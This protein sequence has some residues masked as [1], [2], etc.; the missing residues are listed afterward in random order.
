MDNTNTVPKY[1]MT[2]SQAYTEQVLSAQVQ[3]S[4][5]IDDASEDQLRQLEPLMKVFA[6]TISSEFYGSIEVKLE[7]GK[8]TIIKKTESI[9]I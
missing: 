3:S 5:I 8:V 2:N 7:A 4:R 1:Q 9:K 6:S